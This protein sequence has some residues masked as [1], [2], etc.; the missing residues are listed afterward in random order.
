MKS[1]SLEAL[2][3]RIGVGVA[4]VDRVLNER[5]GVSPETTRRVLEAAREAGLK[6]ILPEER[7][8][9]WQ[10][11]VFLSDNDSRFFSRLT[12]DF[13]DVADSLGYRR[14]TLHRTLVAESAPEK[15]AKSLIRS[16]KKRHAIIVFGN[17][18]QRVY[19]ALRQCREANVPV[20]TLVTDLPG[21]QR[22]CHVGIDQQQ[23]GRTAGMMMGLMAHRPGEVLMLSGRQ[24]FSAHRLRIQGF[25]EVISQ[26]FPHLLLGEVLAGRTTDSESTACWKRPCAATAT[27]WASTI[28][29]WATRRWRRR[30][31]A[32][33]AT[34]SAAG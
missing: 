9:P 2:A 11:E 17:E 22:L 32:I 18:H 26:R 19:D 1:I 8:L 20:I 3:K 16:S 33:A 12:Q 7:R 10:I 15:L 30:W 25:R 4:T 23:A 29:G 34:A 6:R 13:A 21:A 27:W 5:G 28:P 14:L 31:L 24:D